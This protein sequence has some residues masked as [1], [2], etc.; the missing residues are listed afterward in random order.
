MHSKVALADNWSSIGS[1][2]LDRWNLRWNLEA[3]QEVDDRDF[4]GEVAHMLLDDF[5]HSHEIDYRQ[6]QQRSVIHRLKEWLWGKV[7]ILLS[8]W[9]P[10]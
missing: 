6:W 9:K 3:N 5:R 1:S 8:R 2:N 7:D 4:A 10:H